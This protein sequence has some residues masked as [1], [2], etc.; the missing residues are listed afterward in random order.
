MSR[1]SLPLSARV[2]RS[3]RR[4]TA[5]GLV[6]LGSTAACAGEVAVEG[7]P[8]P[9]GPGF[10]CCADLQLCYAVCPDFSG[11]TN[12]PALSTHATFAD[13]TR[14]AHCLAQDES[15]VYFLADDGRMSALVKGT[16]RIVDS[17]F[18]PASQTM[19]DED[20]ACSIVL[21]GGSAYFTLFGLGKIGKVTLGTPGAEFAIGPEG[22]LLGALITPT[23]LAIDETYVYV[24]EL[25]AGTVKRVPRDG[26]AP[27]EVIVRTGSHPRE[28][29]LQD[30]VLYWLDDG[31]LRRM[32]KTG[33]SV[34]T[35]STDRG[36]GLSAID[37]RVY[38]TT[39]E[40]LLSVGQ[41][42]DRQPLVWTP[43][44]EP[45]PT[46]SLGSSEPNVAIAVAEGTSPGG[47][48]AHTL[49]GRDILFASNTTIYR[50]GLLGGPQQ[51]GVVPLFDYRVPCGRLG[52]AR[53]LVAD[54]ARIYWTDRD[55][56]RS[57]PF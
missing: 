15:H 4:L 2:A 34:A 10:T 44:L 46:V 39:A 50:T 31:G 13:E 5:L 7:R 56:L 21:D 55:G 40:G 27:G 23:A 20:P 30:S 52:A 42:G 47:V 17:T 28:L 25:D 24:T 19:P 29:L 54:A 18:A 37:G 49:R 8:C 48:V 16:G 41:S 43:P 57:R 14:R 12:D 9:C 11:S 32:D 6:A 36:Q 51:E 1:L 3:V 33:G 53:L 22:S 26:S 35:L 38:W 45:C